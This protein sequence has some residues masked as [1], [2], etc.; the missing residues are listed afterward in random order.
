MR[1]GAQA[2]LA[3]VTT[4]LAA[5]GC[6]SPQVTIT[7]PL[8]VVNVSPHDG[9]TGIKVDWIVSVCMT[10]P[11]DPETLDN[12]AIRPDDGMGK[13][14][15]TPLDKPATL[16]DA[17]RACFEF[18]QDPLLSPGTTYYVV[19]GPDLAAE[20]GTKLGREVTSEFTTEP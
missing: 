10:R 16:T 8:G 14:G 11:L 19:L 17:D 9:A 12:V 15:D 20:D 2:V 13:P 7:E 6:G 1:L 3:S 4:L 18:S 5:A